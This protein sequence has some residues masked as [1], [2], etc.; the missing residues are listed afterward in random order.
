MF[1]IMKVGICSEWIG[2]IFVAEH[3]DIALVHLVKILAHHI[4][5]LLLSA[6]IDS[7]TIDLL[8]K[9]LVSLID[10]L[11]VTLDLGF[12]FLR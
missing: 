9:Q 8:M 7:G 11:G 1:Y 3:L 12:L 4:V 10:G 6:N 2:L 5:N